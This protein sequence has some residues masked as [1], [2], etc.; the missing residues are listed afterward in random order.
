MYNLGILAHIYSV[1]GILLVILINF[2]IIFKQDDLFKLRRFMI[3]F[4]PMGSVMLGSAIFTGTILMAAKHLDFTPQNIT[5]IIVGIALIIL[6]A[7]RSK[8]LRY[9]RKD[10]LNTYKITAYKILIVEMILIIA[11]VGF[12]HATMGNMG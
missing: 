4:T 3:I 2:T 5:M 7:K 9:T 8:A 1:Y 12:V 6:E 11:T 10:E